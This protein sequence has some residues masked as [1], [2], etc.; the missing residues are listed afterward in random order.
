M[1]KT[2]AGLRTP[3]LAA[4][5][6][7]A[8]IFLIFAISL[9]VARLAGFWRSPVVITWSSASELDT[10]GFNLLRGTSPRGPF[11]KINAHLIPPS[12]D[13]LLGGEYTYKDG[14]A[15]SHGPSYYLLQT[16][17]SRGEVRDLDIIEVKPD[18]RQAKAL[19]LTVLV[20]GLAMLAFT[21]RSS[22]KAVSKATG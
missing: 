7:C 21:L 16:V 12:P 20:A 14:T 1:S 11:V 2:P 4:T 6:V 15:Y 5:T 3:F 13:P 10:A 18:R 22:L 17:T 19:W 9:A 8:V